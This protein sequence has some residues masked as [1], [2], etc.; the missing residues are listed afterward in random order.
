MG[1]LAIRLQIFATW[2]GGLGRTEAHIWDGVPGNP[3]PTMDAARRAEGP[4]RRWR[5]SAPVAARH[6]SRLFG[7]TQDRSGRA[8]E[9][10]RDQHPPVTMAGSCV[11][12]PWTWQRRVAASCLPVARPG[13]RAYVRKR[14]ATLVIVDAGREM[15]AC[16]G[17]SRARGGKGVS[18]FHSLR[19]RPRARRPAR[20]ANQRACPLRGHKAQG[21]NSQREA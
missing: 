4:H 6:R 7:R 14:D 2:A 3:V 12:A 15:P 8:E 16:R 18:P 17:P 19:R 9:G 13:G 1:W 5:G 21:A 11:S 20:Q 10:R